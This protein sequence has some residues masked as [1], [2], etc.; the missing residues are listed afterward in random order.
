VDLKF[1]E[2]LLLL[3]HLNMSDGRSSLESGAIVS[4]AALDSK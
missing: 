2:R 4:K 1:M 3:I